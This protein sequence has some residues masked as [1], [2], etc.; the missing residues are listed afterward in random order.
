MIIIH[1]LINLCFFLSPYTVR[2]IATIYSRSENVLC[3]LNVSRA[4]YSRKKMIRYNTTITII[5]IDSYKKCQILR[6]RLQNVHFMART[7]FKGCV[8]I[9]S[10]MKI[11]LNVNGWMSRIIITSLRGCGKSICTSLRES[12]L[13][14]Y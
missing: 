3:I 5:N 13:A 4:K 12:I 14:F 10:G 1:F 8:T 11:V 9:I 6:V 7:I 2:L